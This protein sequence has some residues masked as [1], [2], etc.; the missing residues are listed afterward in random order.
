MA[1]FVLIYWL[2]EFLLSAL[3]EFRYQSKVTDAITSQNLTLLE[4]R[5]RPCFHD[6]VF[7][8]Y[9]IGDGDPM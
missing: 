2:R 3:F 4:G 9:W 8:S 1:L 5:F 7:F 6:T